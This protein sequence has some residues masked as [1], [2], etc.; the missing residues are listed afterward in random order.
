MRVAVF[1]L[2]CIGCALALPGCATAAAT[3]EAAL[4]LAPCR[5][6]SLGSPGECGTLEVAENPALEGGRRISLRVVRLRARDEEPAADPIFLLAGGPGQAAT[7]AY[8][9]LLPYFAAIARRRDLV[10]IDQR[11]T[12]S[13]G[14][15]DCPAEEGLESELADGAL[16]RL[17]ER[18]RAGLEGDLTQYTTARAADDLEA[19]RRALGYGPIDLVGVS[20]GTRLALE[21]ARRHPESVRALVIDGVA[22][23]SM[24]IP[25]SFA[26]DAQSALEGVARAC[27]E[28][29]S[30]RDRFG[31]LAPRV[32]KALDGLPRKVVLRDPREGDRLELTLTRA[33]VASA[34]RGLLYSPELM[35]L[36]PL[37]LEQAEAGEFQ[38]LIAQA[39]LLGESG[40][41]GLSLGLMLSVVCSEDVA[42]IGDDE[43]LRETAGTFLGSTV[44]DEFRAAC[45][46]WPRAELEPG[47]EEPVRAD[48]PVLALSGDLDPATPPRW[49]E[50][51][52]ATLPRSRHLVVPGASHGTLMRSCTASLVADYL[53][54][55]EALDALDASCLSRAAAKLPFFID[56]AGPPQ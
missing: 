56:F 16:G 39:A 38:S 50:D 6:P 54:A 36:L 9:P 7:E 27:S 14:P 31:A 40:E 15:L 34:L 11:G 26:K 12:G 52:V 35:A 32:Q 42:R 1:A 45:R 41:E 17:A 49:A 47:F 29:T 10:M 46:G 21:F 3:P 8:P 25:L 30:C 23:R 4:E 18:C 28:E 43:V 2:A 5:V 37:T 24:K 48:V 22:P 44:V 53:D 20:Y 33:V 13:S 19:V 51:A 55:P